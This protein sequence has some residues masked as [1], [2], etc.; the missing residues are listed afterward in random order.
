[1][2]GAG[3]HRRGGAAVPSGGSMGGRPGA[4]ASGGA[5]GCDRARSGAKSRTA[6]RD[7][8]RFQ[9]PVE[10]G[11]Q[12]LQGIGVSSSGDE[13]LDGGLQAAGQPKV[14]CV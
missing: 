10:E 13:D 8:D 1:M 6:G 5:G 11:H 3:E 12:R 14:S 9:V 4:R 2:D 7:R